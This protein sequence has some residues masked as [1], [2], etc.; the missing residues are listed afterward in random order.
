MSTPISDSFTPT[1]RRPR[2]RKRRARRLFPLL[3]ALILLASVGAYFVFT[4]PR[5]AQDAQYPMKYTEAIQK[6]SQEFGLEPAHVAAVILCESSYRPQAVSSAGAR[7]LMQ[8][9]PKTGKWIA[10]KLDLEAEYTDDS[11]FDPEINI[12]FGCWFLSYL[13]EKYDGDITRTTAAYHAGE[14]TVKKW[15]QQEENSPDGVNLSSIPS[16]VTNH[17]V[18]KVLHAY[19]K[20]KPLYA[21]QQAS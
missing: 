3:I 17:Y 19:E 10:Q 8:L 7:G 16:D 20:Y 21:Q 6:Y 9:M 1:R 18:K 12:R 11:L 5:Q 14:G 13:M 2:R 15:L 4:F